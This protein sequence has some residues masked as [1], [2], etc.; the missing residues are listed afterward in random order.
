MLKI[1]DRI[2]EIETGRIMEV[3]WFTGSATDLF[4]FAARHTE[5]NLIDRYGHM[6]L[7]SRGFSFQDEGVT[8]KLVR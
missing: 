8:W 1:G 2:E 7:G 6:A 5:T 3:E 4:D